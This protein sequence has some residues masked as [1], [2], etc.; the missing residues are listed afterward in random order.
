MWSYHKKI[1]AKTSHFVWSSEK[2]RDP[3]SPNF[4]LI[5]GDSQH[6]KSNWPKNVRFFTLINSKN[7]CEVHTP[8][9]ATHLPHNFTQ[10]VKFL[11]LFFMVA[12][13]TYCIFDISL[14]NFHLD[15]L[16]LRYLL[17]GHSIPVDE[18][19][20]AQGLVVNPLYFRIS[21]LP[22]WQIPDQ[23]DSRTR[24]L[25]FTQNLTHVFL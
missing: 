24:P 10:S 1:T 21:I 4:T 20:L 5:S 22:H 25:T 12:P 18:D 13:H 16:E 7:H 8:N 6:W 14:K 19:Q 15:N 9:F 17:A 2:N 11:R 3:P 23:H